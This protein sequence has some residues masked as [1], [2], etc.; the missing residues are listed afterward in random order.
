MFDFRYHVVSLAAVFLALVVGIVVG[1]GLSGQGIV[2]ESERENFNR[3]IAELQAEVDALEGQAEQERFGEEFLEQSYDAVMANRL[4]GKSIAVLFVGSA[5]DSR[6]AITAAIRDAGGSL[7]RLR[8]IQLPVDEAELMAVAEQ[9]DV[10]EIGRRLGQELLAG[11]ET[12]LWD[13]LAEQLVIERIPDL[14]TP[15]DAVVVTRTAELQSGGTADFLSGLY[16]GLSGVLPAVWVDD[17]EGVYPESFSVVRG[18][19]TTLGRVALAVLLETGVH[20]E[21]GPGSD[22]PVPPIP[23]VSPPPESE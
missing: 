12:P 23:P 14:D 20:G 3:R 15:A 21:Y 4:A 18:V 19:E 16:D 7:V 5:S 13:A 11:G 1:V 10:R 6:G 2:K 22:T 8:V 9:S 17:G